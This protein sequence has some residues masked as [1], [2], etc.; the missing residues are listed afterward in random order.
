MDAICDS[1]HKLHI[2]TGYFLER[3]VDAI[4]KFY[5]IDISYAE[6]LKHL[7]SETSLHGFSFK[8]SS[9]HAFIAKV[10]LMYD[11]II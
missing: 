7:N 5:C 10:T 11:E 9:V 3:H 4:V 2:D 1:T 8:I 6:L